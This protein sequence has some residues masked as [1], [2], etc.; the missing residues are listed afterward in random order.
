[1]NRVVFV[2]L[3]AVSQFALFVS[4]FALSASLF[5]FGIYLF[6]IYNSYK[7]G[8]FL[9]GLDISDWNRMTDSA[10]V[11]RKPITMGKKTFRIG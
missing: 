8:R 9:L 2:K 3:T 1:M 6:I 11:F 7:F 5:R 10:V 4:Q